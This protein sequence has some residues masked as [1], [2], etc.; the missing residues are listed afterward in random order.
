MVQSFSINIKL[1]LPI[2]FQVES[3]IIQN[4]IVNFFKILY[5]DYN[6]F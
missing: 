3:N 5:L 4:S 2:I 1:V 6:M